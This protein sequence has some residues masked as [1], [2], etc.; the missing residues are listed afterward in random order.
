MKFPSFRKRDTD[1]GTPDDARQIEGERA[2]PSVNKS[3]GVQAKITNY[4]L[5]GF[6][7]LLTVIFLWR[8]YAGLIEK[9]NAD[10][11]AGKHD[12]ASTQMTNLP[13]L[14]PPPLPNTPTDPTG[15]ANGAPPNPASGVQAATGPQLGPDGKPILSP[16]EQ[17]QQRRFKS[18]IF[19][20]V[21]RGGS[22]GAAGSAGAALSNV[23]AGAT[24]G[25]GAGNAG[26][27]GG[28]GLVGGGGNDAFSRS[29]Q[30]TKTEAAYAYMMPH[31]SMT[32]P[33][34][35]PIP[36]ALEPA[37][38]SS[39]PG[40]VWCIQQ[41]DVY[42]ADGK[43]LLIE[44]GTKWAGQ[45]K[46]ALAQGMDRV[47]IIWVRGETPKHVLIEPDS[48]SA[49]ELGR[50]GVD[51]QVDSHFW[52]RFGSAL[53]FSLLSD[54]SQYAIAKQQNSGGGSNNTTIGFG[55]TVGG[56][57]D[58]IN[59]IL[60]HD[61]DIPDVLKKNQGGVIN[62]LLARDLDLSTVYDLQAKQ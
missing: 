33:M 40:M 12:N 23:A 6:V 26:G 57:T 13:P 17:L 43:V 5:F 48:A 45:Q 22:S 7:I 18:P 3:M 20:A 19:F 21:A 58:V 56:S 16:A 1:A 27:N 29:L 49:D 38:D 62:I 24:G 39:L 32:V 8:Y 28:G 51:G 36:C 47:G 60:K 14:S 59:T 53:L 46:S 2:M 52:K 31:P 4:L 30:G 61:I 15:A 25:N 55:Q 37:I 41:K 42:S 10:R 34:T 11:D 50:A 54:A 35:E 9:H 44:R